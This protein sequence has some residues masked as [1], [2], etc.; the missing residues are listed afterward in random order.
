MTRQAPYPKGQLARVTKDIVKSFG[1][2]PFTV[3]KVV[4]GVQSHLP[5]ALPS[6]IYNRVT[7]VMCKLKGELDEVGDQVGDQRTFQ[8]AAQHKPSYEPDPD[9]DP[10]ADLDEDAWF[11]SAQIG[12]GVVNYVEELKFQIQ[13]LTT[14][15]A[16]LD[17]NNLHLS[18]QIN[19]LQSTI[20]QTRLNGGLS[21]KE[22]MEGAQS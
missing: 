3:A 21:A 6:S 10:P 19:N 9:L 7:N 18:E 11:T 4:Q 16:D 13:F 8:K 2:S 5:L 20:N 12:K 1:Y 15:V 17:A 14:Q 22:I